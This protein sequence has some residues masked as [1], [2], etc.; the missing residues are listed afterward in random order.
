MF[1][2]LFSATKK[3]QKYV[4]KLL[5]SNTEIHKLIPSQEG[6]LKVILTRAIAERRRETRVIRNLQK[7][8]EAK[9]ILIVDNHEILGR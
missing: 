7:K 1:M 5:L 6:T 8:D 2:F 9:T 3:V 4:T